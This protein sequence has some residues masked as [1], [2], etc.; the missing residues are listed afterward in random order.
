MPRQG[1][2]IRAKRQE[3]R[4]KDGKLGW[5]RG[6]SRF[7]SVSRGKRAGCIGSSCQK[8][9]RRS[10]TFIG[11]W[12]CVPGL[13]R[14]QSCAHGH[15]IRGQTHAGA[16]AGP[17]S[18]SRSSLLSSIP[19]FPLLEPR[20]YVLLYGYLACPLYGFPRLR[21][22]GPRNSRLAPVCEDLA[23]ADTSEFPLTS[24]GFGSRRLQFGQTT[25]GATGSG[26]QRMSGRNA[27]RDRHRLG[28]TPRP[29]PSYC[30][31]VPLV[32]SLG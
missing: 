1:Q 21:A 27:V 16:H 14:S 20:I 15:P 2:P 29:T 12:P 25:P 26:F 31:I 13:H 30:G 10:P 23:R 18:K 6:F 9:G 17:S 28:T 11:G 4:A 7:V 32:S 3:S 22:P 5:K 8:N 24:P 19:N